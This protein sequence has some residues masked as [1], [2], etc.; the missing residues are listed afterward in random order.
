M[1]TALI[2]EPQLDPLLHCWRFYYTKE[3]GIVK[4]YQQFAPDCETTVCIS[5]E[6]VKKVRYE[7]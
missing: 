4:V 6:S 5:S 1:V 3:L 7:I 2:D